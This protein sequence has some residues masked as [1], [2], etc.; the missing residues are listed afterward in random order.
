MEEE[1][2][3][4]WGPTLQFTRTWRTTYKIV[5]ATAPAEQV[6]WPTNNTPSDDNNSKLSYNEKEKKKKDKQ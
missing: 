1:I 4:T 3:H 2:K 5:S 6:G